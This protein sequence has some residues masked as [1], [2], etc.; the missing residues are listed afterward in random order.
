[1]TITQFKE[2][3]SL[4]RDIFRGNSE[5][6]RLG[7]DTTHYSESYWKLIDSLKQEIFTKEG[8]DWLHAYLFEKPEGDVAWAWETDGTPICRNDEELYS[9]LISNKYFK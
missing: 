8:L 2:L 9:F 6:Y 7:I 1:M 4:H 3:I 5:L